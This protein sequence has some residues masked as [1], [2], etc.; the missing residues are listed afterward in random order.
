MMICY[1]CQ[2]MIGWIAVSTFI[3]MLSKHKNNCACYRL[4]D[5]EACDWML[6]RISMFIKSDHNKIYSLFSFQILTNL[7]L[8]IFYTHEKKIVHG[9]VEVRH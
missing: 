9:L 3:F 2:W 1:R 7:I 5:F 6:W 8:Y 4:N